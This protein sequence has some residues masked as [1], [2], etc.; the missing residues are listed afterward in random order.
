MPFLLQV[1]YIEGQVHSLWTHVHVDIT[2]RLLG[3]AQGKWEWF[4][5]R[6]V[7]L[8]T[9]C[10]NCISF[11]VAAVTSYHKSCG[12]N[13]RDVSSDNSGPQMSE[14]KEPKMLLVSMEALGES[15]LKPLLA[16]SICCSRY[17]IN[18]KYAILISACL[19]MLFF[20]VCLTFFPWFPYKGPCHC[21]K[22]SFYSNVTS[23]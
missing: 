18:F 19:Q 14:I 12:L 11:F 8:P 2:Q 21:V 6:E 13:K 3:T 10:T 20:F 17:C 16:S 5:N 23:S 1:Q 22:G 15:C 9:L 4:R 7:S